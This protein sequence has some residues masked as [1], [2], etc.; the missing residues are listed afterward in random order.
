MRRLY[1]SNDFASEVMKSLA[2]NLGRLDFDSFDALMAFLSEVAQQK[3]ID[4]YRKET[5][6]IRDYSTGASQPGRRGGARFRRPDRQQNS[7]EADEARKVLLDGKHEP[8]REIIALKEFG[9]SNQEVAN[10]IGW[11][12]KKVQRFLKNLEDRY[13]RRP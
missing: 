8:E 13:R 2:A 5:A 6:Q 9:Y 4:Q 3:V 7:A 11:N 1:D 10:R 12:I